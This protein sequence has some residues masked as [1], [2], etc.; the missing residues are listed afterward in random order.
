[1]KASSDSK[2]KYERECKILN[3]LAFVL[4]NE[5]RTWS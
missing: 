3:I 4:D 1:M 2:S 5:A